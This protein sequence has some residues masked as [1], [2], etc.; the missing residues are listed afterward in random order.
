MRFFG[1]FVLSLTLLTQPPAWAAEPAATRIWPEFKEIFNLVRS[2][3]VNTSEADLN[4][5]AVEGFINQLRPRVLLVQDAKASADVPEAALISK[6]AV[7]ENAYA[8]IRLNR[9]EA[10][11]A[12]QATS[13]FEDLR[14]K[15][16]LNGLILDLRFTEGVNYGAAAEMADKFVSGE[17]PL[18]QWDGH[19]FRSSTK[20]DS[21]SLPLTILVNQRTSGAAEALAAVLREADAGLIIGSTTAGHAQVFQDIPLSTGGRLRIA[22]APVKTGSGQA[23]GSN[24]ITPDI[25]LNVPER[26]ERAYLED[27]YRVLSRGEGTT[28]SAA[29]ARSPRRRLNEAELVRLQRE[30]GDLSDDGASVSGPGEP[31]VLRDPALARGLDLL[32][33]LAVVQRY[34]AR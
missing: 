3:L 33:G 11:L 2:N 32:K 21:W 12:Q 16:K 17:R 34:R 25:Q 30:G 19:V 8:Y 18:L 23:I 26:D 29:A 31:V 24:G 14:K 4:Q 10:D 22:T 20:G 6:Y 9:V 15:H 5:A 1:Y 7:Y 13:A 28:N 27:P